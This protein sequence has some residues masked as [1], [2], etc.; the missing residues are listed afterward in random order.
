MTTAQVRT[1][2][3]DDFLKGLG[4]SFYKDDERLK[5]EFCPF[6]KGGNNRDRNTFVVF[7]DEGNYICSRA[8]CNQIG[9]FY[10]LQE[11]L[12]AAKPAFYAENSKAHLDRERKVLQFKTGKDFNKMSSSQPTKPTITPLAPQPA[13]RNPLPSSPLM[14]ISGVPLT[15]M[16]QRGF[17]LATLSA[18]GIQQSPSGD[19]AYVYYRDG[20]RVDTKYRIARKPA[21][22]EAKCRRDEPTVKGPVVGERCFYLRDFC[23]PTKGDTLVITAGEANTAT[24]WMAGIKHNVVNGPDGESSIKWIEYEWD[25]LE[26]FKWI[27]LWAD[28]DEGGNNWVEKIVS[29]LGVGRVKVVQPPVAANDAN[30]TVYRLTKTHG[31]EEALRL[32]RE[33]VLNA[34]PLTIEDLYVLADVQPKEVNRD[35]DLCGLADVDRELGG[36]RPG[37]T[38]VSGDTGDGKSTGLRCFIAEFVAQGLPV[39]WWDG[40]SRKEKSQEKFDLIVAGPNYIESKTSERTGKTWY[41]PKKGLP[42]PIN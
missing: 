28:Q 42:F 41:T 17:D 3:V 36:F 30:E 40:E 38:T 11:K 8:S 5:F 35:G 24:L 15:Y 37:L 32:I 20:Q 23:D 19:I 27:T 6:C 33:A 26:K 25:L 34:V 10:A 29:R 14:P 4:L 9:T 18:L 13:R 22:G 12:T 31:R 21:N 7:A 16:Q 39:F 1:I 2:K